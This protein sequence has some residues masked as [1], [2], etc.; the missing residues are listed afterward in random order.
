MKKNIS[1]LL[2]GLLTILVSFFSFPHF[3]Y[4]SIATGPERCTPGG[5]WGWVTF[6]GETGINTAIGC[7]PLE[8]GLFGSGDRNAGTQAFTSFVL[9]WAT[10]LGGGIAFILIV[11]AGFMITTS[12]GD[13]KRLQ[14]GKELL[15][16]AISGLLMLIF[17]IFILRIIGVDILGL[18]NVGL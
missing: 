2:I 9:R 4:A 12:A 7:V 8:I 6:E 13:P 14:A 18:E 15:T 1:K 17:A 3:S 11:Y 16:A 10:G 5:F